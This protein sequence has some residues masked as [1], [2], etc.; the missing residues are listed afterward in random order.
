ME[1]NILRTRVEELAAKLNGTVEES[2]DFLVMKVESEQ[3]FEALKAAKNFEDVPCDFL[4]DVAGVD[5][6]E[7][8]EVVYHLTS[9]RGKQ[10]LRIKTRIPRENPRISSAVPLWA[11][12]NWLEREAYDMFGI[13]FK[14]HP[15]LSRIYM[16]NDFEGYP[17]RKDYAIPPYEE[18]A[19]MRTLVEGE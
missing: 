14:G 16:W 5:L 9:L 3:V 8:F 12:A 19:K 11:G 4:H 1:N 7:H 18:R 13:I 2:L 10:K 6:G 17:L 15:N